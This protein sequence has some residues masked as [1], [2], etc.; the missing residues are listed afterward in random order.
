MSWIIVTG[1]SGSLGCEIAK[2]ILERGPYG[3]IGLCRTKTGFVEKLQSDFG[4]RFMH[5]KFDLEDIEGIKGLYLQTIKEKGIIYGLVNNS[6]YG[7]D[8]IVTNAK[9]E[10]LEKMY[11]I[12][13]LAPIMLT[14][15]V[16]RDMLLHD[17][18]G[19]IVHV[20]SVSAHTG[21]KG[22]AM[23]A[24][25]KGALEAFSKGIAREWGTKGIR[26]NCVAPGFMQ[27][28]MTSTLTDA[29]KDSIYRRT[30]LK[31]PTEIKSVAETVYFILT[32]KSASMTGEVIH[33]D[34]GTI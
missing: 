21:Y 22:L 10:L 23:Y 25:T 19:A 13:V 33:V 9:R 24:S 26:S 18:K 16:I 3:V 12:N 8:D 32:E 5:I 29:Q 34:S 15:Y 28:A 7:Y 4:D 6:A 14:K 27:T 11:R 31:R 30:A 1:V 2:I 20:S 17:T